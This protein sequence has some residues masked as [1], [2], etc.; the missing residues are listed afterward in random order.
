MLST[1]KTLVLSPYSGLFDILISKDRF[2]PRFHDEVDFSFVLSELKDKYCPDNG[3][4]AIDPIY[5]FKCLILKTVSG[6]SDADLMDEIKVNLEYKYFLDMPPEAFPPESSTLCVFRRQRLKD[7]NLMELLLNRTLEM[8]LERGIIKRAGSHVAARVN[9]ILD[10]THTESHFGIARPVPTLKEWSKKL[11]AELYRCDES[12][13]GQV[14]DDHKIGSTAL[15]EEMAYGHR[16]IGYVQ[17]NCAELLSIKRVSRVFNRFKELID[18]ITEYY[19]VNPNDKDARVGHKS[20]DTEFFGY[21]SQIAIDEDSRLIL[22][23]EVTSGEVGDAI[24]GIEVM[25]RITSNANLSVNELLAD[26]AY[27]GQPFLELAQDKEFKLIAPPHPILGSSIDGREGFTF[28]KDADM[29]CCPKGHLAKSKRTVTYKK[30]NNRRAI[31]YTFDPAKCT[32]C[33]LR[34]T[35]IKGKAQSR[36]F[37]V[38]VLT[39]Q[40]KRLLQEYQTD[41]FKTRRRQRYK[42]EAKNAHL[43]QSYGMS[44][45]MGLGIQMMTLQA[46]VAFFTSNIKIILAQEAGK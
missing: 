44:K 9:I 5:L 27:S 23:A 16:L 35:C 33:P 17:D 38:S 42:I 14:E 7:K 28:N 13:T 36:S 4:P 43:K 24:P 10:G 18:D 21:K 8:A 19:Q 26:T 25:K 1:Q 11:R 15:F 41:Y 31:I 40:Q 30:D 39:E 3:R 45:T 20:A 37:S 2:L 46:A 6:L 32:A 34:S 29:F 12:L 22:D